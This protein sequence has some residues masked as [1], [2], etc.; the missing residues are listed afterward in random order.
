MYNYS[1]QRPYVF[2]EEGQK[3]LFEV[4]SRIGFLKNHT[5]IATAVNLVKNL[6]GDSWNHMTIINYLEEREVIQEIKLKD[7]PFLQNRIFKLN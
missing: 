2:T 1:E 3:D 7:T 4:L 6:L 5:E